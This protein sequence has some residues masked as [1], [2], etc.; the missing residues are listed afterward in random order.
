MVVGFL[1]IE[2]TDG[3][4]IQGN[5]DTGGGGVQ[6]DW[7]YR[8][9][10]LRG[11]GGGGGTGGLECSGIGVHGEIRVTGDSWDCFRCLR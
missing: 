9:M 3:L 5:G 7:G 8:G 10:G 11:G 2:D 4:G 1:A 6:A